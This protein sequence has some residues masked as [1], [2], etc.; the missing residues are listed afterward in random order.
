[1]VTDDDD[2]RARC[3]IIGK[4]NFVFTPQQYHIRFFNTQKGIHFNSITHIQISKGNKIR[5]TGVLLL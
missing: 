4:W 2:V 1:M 5:L 3:Y